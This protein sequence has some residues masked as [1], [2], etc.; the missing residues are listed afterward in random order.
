MGQ[1]ALRV[2]VVT[3]GRP[4]SQGRLAWRLLAQG[5]SDIVTW[6]DE[7]VDASAFAIAARLAR[8]QEV[9]VLVNSADV[10]GRLVGRSSIW[11]NALAELVEAARVAKTPVL[12]T[13]ESGTGK[14]LAA[15]MIDDLDP[16]P[17]KKALV[18]LD[19]TTIVPTLSGLEFFG[20]ERGAFTDAV[21]T[22]D[23]AFAEADGG[24]LF[25]DELAELP[26]GLQ[27]ELLRVI[28]EGMYKRVGSGLWRRTRFRLVC[29]TNRDLRQEVE[30]KRF[31][32]D[33]YHR[34]AAWTVRLPS[35]RD[36]QGDVPL[37]AEH[38]LRAI[39]PDLG[40]PIS[41][42]RGARRAGATQLPRQRA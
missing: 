8:W 35:L 13:G 17:D 16:R 40:T 29:A 2:L 9:D 25:L 4:P 39:R 30:K 27:A 24:T 3:L 26:L 18:V 41:R 42:S 14:E 23:G 7:H 5:A 28:Q 33:L 37:L 36:R 31:R 11:M 15:R 34:I 32:N 6:D 21:A 1:G 12:I 22:R 19:C 38:L 20:H 10:R